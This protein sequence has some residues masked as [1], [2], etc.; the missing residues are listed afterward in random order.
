MRLHD[1]YTPTE[2]ISVTVPKSGYVRRARHGGHCPIILL[3]GCAGL[4]KTVYLAQ[5]AQEWGGTVIYISLKSEDNDEETLAAHIYSA[6]CASDGGDPFGDNEVTVVQLITYFIRTVS[7]KGYSILIDNISVIHSVSAM[8]IIERIVETAASGKCRVAVAGRFIPN[9]MLRYLLGEVCC[10]LT[11]RELLFTAEETAENISRQLP[12]ES[13][14]LSTD[15]GLPSHVI[16]ESLNTFAGGWPAAEVMILKEIARAKDNELNLVSA[17]ERSYLRSFVSYNILEMLD[18]ELADYVKKTAFLKQCDEKLSRIVLHDSGAVEKLSY[19]IAHG[20]LVSADCTSQ[21]PKYPPAVRQVLA[22]MIPQEEKKRLTEE[23]VS[24]YAANGAIAEAVSLL[25]E[26]GDADTVENI[27]CRFGRRLVENREFELIGYCAQV[28]DRYRTPSNPTAL[29]I[30]AQYYYYNELY[31]EMEHALNMADSMFGKENVYSAY[32]GLYNGLLKY[33]KNPELYTANVR[34]FADYILNNG[35]VFPYLSANDKELYDRLIRISAPPSEKPLK[36]KRF[37]GF[38][39]TSTLYDGELTWRTKKACEFM[40]YMIE[41]GGKPI[42]RERLMDILWHDN[43][44]NNAVAMLHNIIYSLRRELSMPELKNFISYK[45]KSYALDMTLIYDEDTEV[46]SACRA[47][48]ENNIP[49]LLSNQEIFASYWGKYLANIDCDWI[50]ELREHYDKLFV[51]GCLLLA[52]HFHKA[53]AFTKELAFLKNAAAIDPYSEQIT[54]DIIYCQISLGYP[55]KAKARY[56]EYCTL[57]GEELGI[58]P[59]KWLKKE[60]LACFSENRS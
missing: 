56:E 22:G 11:A 40:A 35:H 54:R 48:S 2:S 19:L 31:S 3:H 41:R 6:L 8:K 21:Y 4:G 34:R 1:F 20:I 18:S 55:N 50:T 57:I 36:V 9:F 15:S 42:V 26:W 60:F 53:G 17:T 37:G 23:A 32:R 38:A 58:E 47:V 30:L 43:M 33:E 44:P 39:I 13:A 24:Y 27:L 29:G 7:E 28:I 5:L 46:L 10:E 16:A 25:G 49:A 12:T 14:V 45:E 52:S 59:S 51:D